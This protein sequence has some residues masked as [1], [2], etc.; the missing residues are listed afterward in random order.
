MTQYKLGYG[1]FGNGITVWNSLETQ[2]GDYKRIAHISA[3]REVKFYDTLPI[4]IEQEILHY[5]KTANPTISVSQ[6]VPVFTT[7]A[8]VNENDK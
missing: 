1:H 6:E 5:A 8:E 4:E 7:P 2:H 3:D